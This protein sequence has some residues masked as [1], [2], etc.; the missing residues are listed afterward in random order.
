MEN[1]GN[2]DGGKFNIEVS[3]SF[4]LIYSRYLSCLFFL[5]FYFRFIKS[6]YRNK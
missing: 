3:T 6:I 1:V 4:V 2:F 5:L